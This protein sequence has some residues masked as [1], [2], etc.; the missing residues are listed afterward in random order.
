MCL[1]LKPG[2]PKK[3]A[4]SVVGI[5][6]VTLPIEAVSAD[7]VSMFAVPS[8][9][10]SFHCFPPDPKSKVDWPAGIRLEL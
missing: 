1:N 8:I 10:K 4:P 6:L 5:K 2:F 9:Y 3:E 7:N